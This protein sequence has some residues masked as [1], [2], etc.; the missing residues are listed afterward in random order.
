MMKTEASAERSSLRSS[1]PHRNA[2][3]TDF[4]ALRTTFSKT[5]SGGGLT[6]ALAAAGGDSE[7]KEGSE[8]PPSSPP[9]RMHQQLR[10]RKYGSNVNRI[11]NMLFMQMGMGSGEENAAPARI[12]GGRGAPPSPHRRVRA[13][14][15][16]QVAP[17]ARVKQ[18]AEVCDRTSRVDSRR[19]GP[20]TGSKF[21][22]T[23]KLFEQSARV[24][25]TA[26]QPS[27]PKRERKC[28]QDQ[29]LDEQ[30]GAQNLRSDRGSTDS[31][32]ST[33]PRT[34][35]RLPAVSCPLTAPSQSTGQQTLAAGRSFTTGYNGFVSNASS[36]TLELQEQGQQQQVSF[37]SPSV[38]SQH[39]I[40]FANQDATG[41]PRKSVKHEHISSQVALPSEVVKS[42]SFS[43]ISAVKATQIESGI[44][45]CLENHDQHLDRGSTGDF[46]KHLDSGASVKHPDSPQRNAFVAEILSDARGSTA[47]E[48]SSEES[49][50]E[51]STDKGVKSEC[52]RYKSI[53]Q[54]T[55]NE[56][57][58]VESGDD[59]GWDQAY[60]DS[61][62]Q[63]DS[64]ENNYEPILE[65]TE[66]TGLS[67]EDNIPTKRKIK[68]STDPIKV[69]H[70]YSN[71]DYD[72]RNDEVDPVAASAEYELEK[73]VERL[74]LFPVELEK[75][76]DGLGISIIGM[77]VG[78]D[79]GL[80][81]L[82]IFV[83]TV[84]E[85]GAA[86]RDSRIQVNDQIVEVDGISLVGVTQSFAA[87]VLRTTKGKVRFLIGR[88]KP[89]Q[90][91]EVAQ[92]I[93]QTLEQ[94]RHQRELLEQHYV[95]YDADDD[96]TGEYA[97]DEDDDGEVGSVLTGGDMAIEVFDLPET[98]D[99]LSPTEVDANKITH[100]FK[101][102]QIKHFVTE[103]EIQKMK[104][105]L[106]LAEN[107][108]IQW[109]LEKTQLQQS[110]KENKERMLKLESYWI[111]AQTLCHTVNEHL[112]ETQSQYQALDKKY[113]K[114]KKLIKDY[115][116][117]EIEF[118]KHQDAEKKKLEEIGKVHAAE[119][120]KLQSRIAELNVELQKLTRP[121]G[122]QV[123]NNNNIF[124]EE[125][126]RRT[127]VDTLKETPTKAIDSL[128][129][130]Q[131]YHHNNSISGVNESLTMK[132]ADPDEVFDFN[133]AVPETERLDSKA[134]KARVNLSAK[135]KRQRP[136]RARVLDS[137][138]STDG[139]DSLERKD[140]VGESPTSSP[141][142]YCHSAALPSLHQLDNE[143]KTR[144]SGDDSTAIASKKGRSPV[145]QKD[146]TK[147][148]F[149]DFRCPAQKT[150]SKGKKQK[151]KVKEANRLSSG[152]RISNDTLESL[153]S[154]I[155]VGESSSSIPPCV[156]LSW[157]GESSKRYNSSSNL[158]SPSSST[159]PSSESL[160]PEK[161]RFKNFT[162]I[163]DFSPS[164]TSSADLS[165]FVTEPNSTGRSHILALSSDEILDEGQSPKHNQWKTCAVVDWSTH[166]V[167]HWLMGLN[168]EQYVPQFIAKSIDGAQL[169]QLDGTKLKA[170]GINVSRDRA[171]IKKKLKELKSLVEKA[172]KAQQKLEKQREK[173]RKKE[174]EQLLKKNKKTSK[175]LFLAAEPD[176]E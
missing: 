79:A 33:H 56:G 147:Q 3:R 136:S 32:D 101:E 77:G 16:A 116:Q 81:K 139:D 1:S 54:S 126:D 165:G 134:L 104:A 4:Q 105:K 52:S 103:A 127:P 160:S 91:S 150:F 159:E 154:N 137:V 43:Q 125:Q 99:V 69:F 144:K 168:M 175:S 140:A 83:K 57:C 87:T 53:I 89:G 82:G 98:G 50:A 110:I 162:Y 100:K 153:T 13:R 29:L 12:R 31:L 71:E 67:D 39:G 111:E 37:K 48:N 161:Q 138:S 124:G 130:M 109:E 145:I 132:S 149:H 14:D 118:V 17:G 120:Q 88:E 27:S 135:S 6:G 172:R 157:F 156:L 60:E 167:S 30:Q 171:I 38:Q 85:G 68:F 40:D 64:D 107:E 35:T 46:G 129:R 42:A 142:K 18:T 170:L 73:R 21:S 9:Q 45:E 128:T 72:R 44:R 10:G 62:E 112:K 75:D 22:E 106:K 131:T 90:S 102:L 8:N 166:Q 78:A 28:S 114:A 152:S 19:E 176:T 63:L 119:V 133:E 143:C 108:K 25:A 113:N 96:E 55:Q 11:K 74:D 84:T 58:S 34:E 65:C 61:E 117:K 66:V 24:S 47:S 155:S 97:T 80:E 92:L 20:A 26:P 148:K 121:N 7:V 164:S 23:R 122:T 163:D 115:Q 51:R 41:S 70:T 158:P 174:Q 169:L 49:T 5:G 15:V 36:K 93:S 76:E 141:S 151:D 173:Q 2:Y 86:Q 94:E 123:N 59:T 95:Q 146:S